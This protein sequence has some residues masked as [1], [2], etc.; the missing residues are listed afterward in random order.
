M[1]R[2]S[3]QSLA[4]SLTPQQK[5]GRIIGV[6]SG[7]AAGYGTSLV[8]LHRAWYKQDERARF[9]FHNDLSHWNQVDK[10]G[11]FWTAFHQSRAGVDVLKWTGA[12]D[13]KAL[14]YGSL[15]GIVLQ[16]P[17]ELF[18]GYSQEYGASV[19]DMA[20]NTLGSAAVLLQHQLWDQILIMPKFSFHRTNVETTRMEMLGERYFEQMLKDYNG[21]TYWLSV[22]ASAF[23]PAQSRYPRW[24][25]VAVGYGADNMVV[26]DPA[27]NRRL[28]RDSYR[29]YYL[30]LDLNLLNIPTRSGFLK[31]VFYILSSVHLPAPAIEYNRRRGLVFHPVFY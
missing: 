21:Q 31:K 10:A 17:I 8:L 16:T 2:A 1:A 11:H 26:G 3:D 15:V 6:A 4:D 25:N 19:S 14:L 20:A 9:H 12:S 24:L 28:G 13:K 22:D 23:L 30:T 27:L 5:R 29:Q 18:D 7:F